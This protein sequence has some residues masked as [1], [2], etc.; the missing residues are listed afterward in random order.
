MW[1]Q[2]TQHFCFH[3][4]NGE[5]RDK[6]TAS[7]LTSM[8]VKAGIPDLIFVLPNGKTL[9]VELKIKS[10]TMSKPQKRIK[11]KLLHLEHQ[12]LLVQVDSL[13]EALPLLK[14]ALDCHGE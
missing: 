6:K 7:K 12:Y 5:K 10:G 8:G 4:P 13:D 3:V 1:A 11:E 9:W 14:Q 2:E